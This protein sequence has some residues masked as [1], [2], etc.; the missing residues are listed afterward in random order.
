MKLI[1]RIG[2]RNQLHKEHKGGTKFTTFLCVLCAGL[3]VLRETNQN[4]I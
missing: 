1:L 4:I 2:N 3:R